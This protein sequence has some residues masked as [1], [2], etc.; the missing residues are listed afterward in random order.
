MGKPMPGWEVADPRRGRAARRGRASGARSVCGRGRT[1]TIRSATGAT[2]EASEETFGGEW[3]H[4]KDAARPGRGRLLLVRGPRRRRDHLG[5]V[6]HRAV[7][8]R[9]GMPRAPGR[10]RKRRRS[11]RRTSSAATSSRRS[12]CSP[13]ATSPS[14][15]LADE[16]K[17]VRPRAA[18][19]V[20][21]PAAHRVRHRPAEDAHRQDPPHRAARAR[22]RVASVLLAG[23]T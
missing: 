11:P 2:P 8:G 16:I 20:R 4:T 14:D 23:S 12:S 6:P 18:L 15:E 13:R 10:A 17:S 1:R 3:F 7:R 21:L 9:V 5:R 22:A 19:R